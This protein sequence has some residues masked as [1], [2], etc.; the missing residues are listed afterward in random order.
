[1]TA[2]GEFNPVPDTFYYRLSKWPTLFIGY[3]LLDYNLRLLLKTLRHKKDQFPR[4]YSIDPWPIR[5][6]RGCGIHS[7]AM[8]AFSRTT[9]GNLCPN[10]IGG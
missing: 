1:M 3:S 6:W 9:F 8:S 2:P 10:F 5:S 4:S 7:S